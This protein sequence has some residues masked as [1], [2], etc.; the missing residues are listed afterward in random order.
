MQTDRKRQMDRQ[1]DKQMDR[2]RDG[3]CGGHSLRTR[4]VVTL[5][6]FIQEAEQNDP[7]TP[8]EPTPCRT[9]P[10]LIR[11]LQLEQLDSLLFT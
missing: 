8:E 4:G 6:L 3:H 2:Q 10:V 11:V 7:M 5:G 9:S 1:T